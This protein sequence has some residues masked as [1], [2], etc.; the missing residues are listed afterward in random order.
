MIRYL[1]AEQIFV[2]CSCYRIF[3]F[4]FYFLS[5]HFVNTSFQL[6]SI[7]SFLLCYP[8]EFNDLLQIDHRVRGLSFTSISKIVVS[9][10]IL[11]LPKQKNKWRKYIELSS[12]SLTGLLSKHP[13]TAQVTTSFN[14]EIGQK[15]SIFP[16]F[17][18]ILCGV[19]KPN[20]CSN[21]N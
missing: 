5:P 6:Q 18:S 3:L 12:N 7:L 21:V 20:S 17:S 9:I 1:H 15:W 13:D 2:S 11:N 19:W 14:L 4:N 16:F 10:V 8:F